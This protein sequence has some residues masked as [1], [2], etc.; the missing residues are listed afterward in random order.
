VHYRIHSSSCRCSIDSC[1]CVYWFVSRQYGSGSWASAWLWRCSW[2]KYARS[3]EPRGASG[4]C[5]VDSDCAVNL[6]CYQ[7]E[8]GS[9][10]QI[11]YQSIDPS[12]SIDY[13]YDPNDSP[14]PPLLPRA[15]PTFPFALLSARSGYNN[16]YCS[17]LQ[18]NHQSHRFDGLLL[19]SQLKI[20]IVRMGC[21][22]F[23]AINRLI[24]VQ[25]LL[26]QA[27][28]EPPIPPVRWIIATIPTKDS[29][30]ADGLLCFQRD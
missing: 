21:S 8:K 27:T 28:V 9:A 22:A 7:R 16:D 11:H 24:E 14:E 12:G 5:N 29:D 15:A 20:R 3:R 19:R 6:D 1:S 30:C 13:C 10:I 4:D 26:F 2:L 18:W 25:R 23:S 17:R